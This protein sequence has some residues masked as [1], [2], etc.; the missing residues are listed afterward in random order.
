MRTLQAYRFA[1]DP[2]PPIERALHSHV[3][4]KRFAFN[5]GLALVK[6]H[7]DA[8]A[9]GERV[10]IPWTL[11]ALRKRWNLQKETVAPWWRENSKEAYSAGLD[12]LAR[13]LHNYFSSRASTRRGWRVGF[14]KFRKRG[15]GRQSVRFTTGAIYVADRTHVVL[16]RLG[17]IR[18]H[19]PTTALLARLQ[20]GTAR[21]LSAT[22]ACEGDRWYVSF[23]C[24]VARNV[25]RPA[26]PAVVIG[27]DAGLRQLAV[28][29]SGEMIANPRPLRKASRKIARLNRQLARRSRG[30]R[31]WQETEGK[32]RR[33]HARTAHI[34]KDTMA[35]LTTRLAKTY[36]TVVVETLNVIGMCRSRRLAK[37]VAD[38][39]MAALRRQLR[40]KCTWY[41][42][43][44]VEVPRQFP[45]TKTCS[46]C[47]A[48]K[49]T[50]SLRERIFRCDGCGL[51]MDRDYNA[52]QNLAAA[53]R[54]VA[55]S[56]PE[57]Q[58][59]CGG[60]VRPATVGQ[61]SMTREAGLCKAAADTALSQ[62]TAA[63][64]GRIRFR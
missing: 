2:V 4:A 32:L 51:E 54:I 20:A 34:R 62:E 64:N 11:P 5:W 48:A 29:S 30:S 19:E 35:K 3:G 53:A 41:G 22:V 47:G 10:T 28:L 38:T 42:S 18:T 27:V 49:A 17:R 43:T 23:G 55:G 14:P 15:R 46:R 40:Y 16:P 61:T 21:I 60:D 39:G 8:T 50:L 25:G 12:A 58:T 63:G 31:G 13:A 52:A 44:L 9:C 36:G 57:T 56:G 6:S 24:E 59:A 45:S 26:K 1:L 7:L 33:A 37:S